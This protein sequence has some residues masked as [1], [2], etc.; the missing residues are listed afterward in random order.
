[1]RASARRLINQLCATTP[2]STAVVG[3]HGLNLMSTSAQQPPPHKPSSPAVIVHKGLDG[4][5]A[6]R[7]SISTVGGENPSAS[8]TYRGYPVKDLALN[9]DY[10]EV[11]H[12]LIH[13]SL[14]KNVAQ[15][16]VY[17]AKLAKLRAL[18][19]ALTTLLESIPKSAHPMDV[20]R[21][22]ASLLGSLEPEKECGTSERDA[23]AVAERLIASF[24]T[25]LCHWHHWHR[26]GHRLTPNVS[27]TDTLAT[28]FVKMLKV[29]EDESTRFQSESEREQERLHVKVVNASL[30]LYAE[31]DLAAST[32]TARVVAS[33]VRMGID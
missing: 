23:P 8:L 31:H 32:F 28:A 2:S 9:A 14:P 3:A 11:A 1:M 20:L 22:G 21:S 26:S 10:E 16:N 6:E 25:M 33:T 17:V 19:H 15:K 13:G 27:P 12:L 7:T 4:I 29:G 24:G 18:P 30:I 5:C